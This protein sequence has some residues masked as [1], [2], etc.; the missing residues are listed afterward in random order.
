MSNQLLGGLPVRG[1]QIVR[2][3]QERNRVY[4]IILPVFTSLLESC[5][6]GMTS[7]AALGTRNGR[8]FGK[9]FRSV[10]LRHVR[11][12]DLQIVCR[13]WRQP[14]RLCVGQFG[15]GF[16]FGD[17]STPWGSAQPKADIYETVCNGHKPRNRPRQQ[18][19]RPWVCVRACCACEGWSRSGQ[20]R[21]CC[22]CWHLS[23]RWPRAAKSPR[24]LPV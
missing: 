1:G 13:D 14:V 10:V 24:G 23:S 6:L 20:F 16:K 3:A 15:L 9:K 5:P 19:E 22:D 21:P 17:F 18:D 8:S 4:W 7:E 2:S 11:W 12:K